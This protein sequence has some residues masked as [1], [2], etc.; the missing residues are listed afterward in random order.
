[1]RKKK[2]HVIECEENDF[3]L[4]CTNH[5]PTCTAAH[6][7]DKKTTKVSSTHVNCIFR[8]VSDVLLSKQSVLIKE[9]SFWEA[10]DSTD[11][12]FV[13]AYHFSD[14]T[15]WCQPTHFNLKW[16]PCRISWQIFRLFISTGS[17]TQKPIRAVEVKSYWRL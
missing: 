6:W 15:Y 8:S 9:N 11:G 3:R 1:M 2:R 13:L 5:G 17:S 14:I 7:T 12:V 10:E 4:S 16:K